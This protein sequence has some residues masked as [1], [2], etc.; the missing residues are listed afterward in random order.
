MVT[1]KDIVVYSCITGGRDNIKHITHR[2]NFRYVMFT[3]REVKDDCGWE[4]VRITSLNHLISARYH[5]H[6]PQQLFPEAKVSIWLDGTHWPYSSL[7]PLLD[8]LG[9][10]D[11]AASRHFCR[12]TVFEEVTTCAEAGFDAEE[13]FNTQLATYQNEGFPDTLGLYE[14]SYLVRRHT[15]RLLQF[16]KLWWQEMTQHS[17]RDQIS[18]MYCLWKHNFPISTIP[19]QCRLGHNEF[20]KMKPH[21]K[22]PAL[23]L[24]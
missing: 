1:Q 20:F 19:G 2:D 18:L 4:I 15:E 11:I 21:R 22:N 24:L 14:T 8:Y 3:D 10:A 5:K 7:E 9:D 13:T 17:M 23:I 6:H 16:Q 12:S